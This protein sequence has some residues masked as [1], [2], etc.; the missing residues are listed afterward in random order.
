MENKYEV[1]LGKK[2]DLTID[3]QEKYPDAKKTVSEAIDSLE[4][5]IEDMKIQIKQKKTE[6]KNMKKYIT[7][8]TEQIEK[9]ESRLV[10][11]KKVQKRFPSASSESPKGDKP[12]Q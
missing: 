5:A 3:I 6:R 1:V 8:F 2:G 12:K 10:K 11:F 7:S 9:A 4:N